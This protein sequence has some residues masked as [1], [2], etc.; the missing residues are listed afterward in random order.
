MNTAREKS[1][2]TSGN[3]PGA[4]ASGYAAFLDIDGTL[5][6]LAPTPDS[7]DV[8]PELLTLLRQLAARL[9]GALAFV[10]GRPIRGID[11]LFHPLV[12]PAVGVHGVEIRSGN[13]QLL[14]DQHLNE[15]LQAVAPVLQQA[16]ARVPGSQLENK[17]SA[18]A[19]H[20]RNAPERGREV[21]RV[22]EIVVAQLGGEFGVLMG[23]C[24]V[25][26]RPRHA[27]KGAA[28]ERLMQDAPFRGRIP[29][30][31]GDDVTDEDGFDV[32]NRLGG[33]SVHIGDSPTTRAQFRLA[34][35]QALHGWLRQVG[36][37]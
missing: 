26:I 17:G 7:V 16:L 36:V 20:Y 34:N 18:I 23:K 33:V 6:E 29:I 27:T 15:Q 19:L 2:G 30:F 8:P 32:V 11:A 12:L 1:G 4:R 35:P 37:D 10:S 3:L 24:V 25:E 28:I 5:I 14:V 9:D 21:L 22:A 13:G 31:A